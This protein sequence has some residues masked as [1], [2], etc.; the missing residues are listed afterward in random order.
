MLQ[1]NSVLLRAVTREDLPRLWDLV[2]EDL[3][4][5]ALVSAGPPLPR[6]LAHLE[7]EF[8]RDLHAERP[9]AKFVVEADGDVVGRCELHSFDQYSRHCELG[10]A[11]GRQHW[12]RGYGQD[13]VR[14]L[15]DYAFHHLNIHRVQLHVLAHDERAAGAYRRAGFVEE[16]RLRQHAWHEG[17]YRDV[18]VMAILRHERDKLD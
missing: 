3:G 14:A 5:R 17:S 18:L 4:L 15:C 2:G 12:G 6:S 13:A 9:A 8:H 11:L 1:G 16:G 7:E 10:I